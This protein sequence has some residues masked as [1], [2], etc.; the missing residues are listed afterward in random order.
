MR[1]H[2]RRLTLASLV[3]L[4][5]LA[6][7]CTLQNQEIPSL[8]GPSGYALSVELAAS[9]DFVLRDGSSASVVTVTVRNHEGQA[10]SGQ[11]LRLSVTST[12]SAGGEISASEVTTGS[13]GQATYAFYAPS[14]NQDVTEVMLGATPVGTNAAESLTRSVRIAV[15]GPSIP[16]PAFTYSPAA[17]VQFELVAFDASGSTVGGVA[18]TGGCTYVWTFGSEGTATGSLVQHRFQQR[19]S[20]AVTLKVTSA[21]GASATLTKTVS[22][23]VAAK[24]TAA[25]VVSPTDPLIDETVYVSGVTSTVATGSGATIARYIWDFG[26]GESASSSEPT[27]SVSYT[28]ARTYVITLIVEDSNGVQSNAVTKTVTVTAPT[29]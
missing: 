25:F 10:V 17:P 2:A 13:N 5:A 9:P 22:V 6:P 11:R 28:A 12:P 18:C 7:A 29:P 1:T 27:A 14:L 20:H 19:G 3:L 16:A 8:A 4:A 21:S 24:P 26:N 23:A 15:L